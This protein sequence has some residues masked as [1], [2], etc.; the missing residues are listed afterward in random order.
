MGQ[1]PEDDMVIWI[2]LVAVE[3]KFGI[4]IPQKICMFPYRLY[5]NSAY[6][7]SSGR[8]I[9]GFRKTIG[10]FIEP[11]NYKDP[12]FTVKT[13]G[14]ETF[15]KDK[16]GE[17]LPLFQLTKASANESCRD[18]KDLDDCFQEILATALGSNGEN[19]ITDGIQDLASF[20][21]KWTKPTGSSVALKQFRD[22]SNPLK[23]CYQ[24]VIEAPTQI[25]ALNEGGFAL[26]LQSENK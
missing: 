4:P 22:V 18:F 14:F 19:I 6:G 24:E 25:L 8:E 9:Y 12:E 3:K 20:V 10:E 23:A 5:V 7:L 13:L 21:V 1:L 11:Q 15:N 2:P 17:M 16:M 26:P